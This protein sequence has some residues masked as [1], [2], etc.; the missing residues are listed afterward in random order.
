MP[1]WTLPRATQSLTDVA[2]SNATTTAV[3]V[4]ADSTAHTK[5]AWA[6][7]DASTGAQWEGFTLI[8]RAANYSAA[9]DY[10]TLMDIGIGD[11]GSELTIIE[12]LPVGYLASGWTVQIPL[13][14]PS[15][16]RVAAR[17]QSAVTSN[18]KTYSLA[19]WTGAGFTGGGSY[20][21][22][23][24]FG[25]V[26]SASLG[27]TVSGGGTNNTWGDWVE[28]SSATPAPIRALLVGMQA[29]ADTDI[30]QTSVRLEVGFGAAGSEVAVD[31]I[32]ILTN[33]SEYLNTTTRYT[34]GPP[35]LLACTAAIPEGARLAARVMTSVSATTLPSVDVVIIG[36]R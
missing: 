10:S 9:S 31:T 23:V 3:T 11:A 29:N 7:L 28:F 5:G 21:T 4:V 32:A 13:R 27:T 24:T 6:E 14:V 35:A 22:A 36:L 8:G 1:L 12:N 20:Q 30:G 33:S 19:P 18:S 25:A 34:A 15:G 26:T 16:V 17:I 2:W